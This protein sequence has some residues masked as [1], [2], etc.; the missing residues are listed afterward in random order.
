M[1]PLDGGKKT[2]L[3]YIVEL[4]FKGSIPSFIVSRVTTQQPMQ[5]DIINTFLKEEQDSCGGREMFLQKY[6]ELG[7]LT[8]KG[9]TSIQ[10]T[11]ENNT[12][13][14]TGISHVGAPSNNQ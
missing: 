7:P 13:V 2:K 3:T 11:M 10:P 4:D 5:I 6:S 12:A 8:N 1:E 9:E 14:P